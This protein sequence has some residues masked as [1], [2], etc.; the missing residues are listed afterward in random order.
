M[1][2]SVNQQDAPDPSRRLRRPISRFLL[3]LFGWRAEERPLPAKCVLI[4]APHTS[5]WDFPVALLLMRVIGIEGHW[6]AKHTLFRWPTGWLMRRLGG[7][8]VDR[9]ESHNFVD[10]I[11]RLFDERDRLVI[12]I[13]PEGTRKRTEHWKTGFYYIALGAGV[14]IVLG[15]L[16]YPSKRGGVGPTIRPSGN[17]EADL[18]LIRDFYADKTGRHPGNKGTIAVAERRDES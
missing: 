3:R 14:P 9:T 16:D 6:I 11:V 5:N 4:G 8:P 15:Y 18:A 10:Q 1:I 2:R 13:A 7:L 12:T 17:L